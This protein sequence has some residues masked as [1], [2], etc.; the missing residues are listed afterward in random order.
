MNL[1]TATSS[2]FP[3]SE[4]FH[5]RA[6]FCLLA[7]KLIKSCKSKKARALTDHYPHICGHLSSVSGSE[8]LICS[9]GYWNPARDH[10]T[11]PSIPTANA[12][13]PRGWIGSRSGISVTTS[14]SYG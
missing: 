12:S 6:E 5:R 1:V 11:S 3:N 8:E 9:G 4:T 2:A 13:P 14:S 10:A 7:R